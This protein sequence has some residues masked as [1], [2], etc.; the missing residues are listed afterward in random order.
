MENAFHFSEMSIYFLSFLLL[1]CQLEKDC[2][3]PLNMIPKKIKARNTLEK[4]KNKPEILMKSCNFI[5]DI[6]LGQTNF[7]QIPGEAVSAMEENSTYVSFYF[8]G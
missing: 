5:K 6:I 7:F 1:F 8:S 3:K 4:F 2:F